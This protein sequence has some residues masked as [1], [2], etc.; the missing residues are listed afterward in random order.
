MTE[1]ETTAKTRWALAGLAGG[2]VALAASLTYIA[3]NDPHTP[4][5]I[6]P[7]CPY[8]TLTGLDCPGCGGLRMT[9]DV[10]HG[11][12]A[13]AV[14]DNVFLLVGIPLAVLWFLYR[15]IRGKSL[16]SL[17]AVIVLAVGMVAWTVVRNLP[18]FPL[19][20]TVYDG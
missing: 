20:P 12:F 9:Y 2:G 17:T 7:A 15:F 6:F 4:G 16:Y 18:G 3:S 5:A 13:Q 11:D 1:P 8:K 19:V 10:L 14:T